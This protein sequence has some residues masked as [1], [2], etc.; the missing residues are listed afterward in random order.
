ML[1]FHF[2]VSVRLGDHNTDTDIDC[3][4]SIGCLDPYQ[5][6][7]IESV[8]VHENFGDNK[9]LGILQH[10]D[11]ALIRLNRKVI[12]SDSIQPACLPDVEEEVQLLEGM[13]LTAAGWGHNGTG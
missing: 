2:R 8:I 9:N 6:I 12:F 5:R 3:N 4:S 13:K 1:I 7:G 11:I 10:N